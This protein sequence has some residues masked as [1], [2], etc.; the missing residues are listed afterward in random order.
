VH[1]LCRGDARGHLSVRS[2]DDLGLGLP[3]IQ[4]IYVNLVLILA[5]LCHRTCI[6]GGVLDG[7]K[8]IRRAGLQSLPKL[9]PR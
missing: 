6:A 4:L 7:V 5:H 3:Q 2:P 9:R 1:E 8:L